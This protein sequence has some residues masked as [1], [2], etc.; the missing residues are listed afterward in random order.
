M[1]VQPAMVVALTAARLRDIDEALSRKLDATTVQV[2]LG[3][4][5]VG[6]ARSRFGATERRVL[7]LVRAASDM[8]SGPDPAAVPAG[9]ALFPGPSK[10]AVLGSAGFDLPAYSDMFSEAPGWRA[11]MLRRGT[12]DPFMSL[13]RV[14]T[15]TFVNAV[16]TRAVADAAGAPAAVRR[17][18]AFTMGLMSALAHATVAAPVQ[19]SAYGRRTSKRW[20]RSQP[21]AYNR[22]NDSAALPAARRRHRSGADVP[23][24]VADRR[25]GHAVA[26]Q[27]PRRARSH[28]PPRGSARRR[29]RVARVRDRVHEPRDTAEPGAGEEGLR[30]PGQR[31]RA[32]H[33]G[34]V[35]RRVDADPAQSGP[36]SPGRAIPARRLGVDDRGDGDRTIVDRADHRLRRHRLDHPVHLF[37]DHVGQRRRPAGR[38]VRQRVVDVPPAHRVGGRMDPQHRLEDRRP[39]TGASLGD[40]RRDAGD[41]RLRARPPR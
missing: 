30:A 16:G 18:E 9:S 29:A 38:A 5:G 33:D 2:R 41:R 15:A 14:P 21:G 20:S 17:G 19:R 8:I 13:V 11:A 40:G 12:P 31:P 4:S 24:L 27:L 3:T 28:V 25:A 22:A 39:L 1:T 7:G 6:L 26:H 10:Y 32:V 35:V 36:G 23:G 34:R 37:D